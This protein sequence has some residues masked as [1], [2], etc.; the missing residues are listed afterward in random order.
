MR[1]PTY[2]RASLVFRFDDASYYYWILSIQDLESASTAPDPRQVYSIH[3]V[4]IEQE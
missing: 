4:N 3:T 2:A 1:E